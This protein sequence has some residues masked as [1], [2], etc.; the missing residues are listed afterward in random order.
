M[1]GLRNTGLMQIL[2][3][4]N[5]LQLCLPDICYIKLTFTAAAIFSPQLIEMVSYR[6]NV[7]RK[8]TSIYPGLQLDLI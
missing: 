7:L 1:L 5:F 6:K 3:N 2:M 4:I 8:K